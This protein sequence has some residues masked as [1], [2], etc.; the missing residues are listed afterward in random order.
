MSNSPA[1]ADA[2]DLC[3]LGGNPLHDR[4][5]D[6]ALFH[7]ALILARGA[8]DRRHGVAA[9]L[10]HPVQDKRTVQFA[11]LAIK[12]RV[13]AAAD[14][15]TQ[16]THN[17]THVISSADRL[18]MPMRFSRLW[19]NSLARRFFEHMGRLHGGTGE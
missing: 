6:G 2:Y 8:A 5:A 19:G 12:M 9:I 3:G 4:G 11:P 7:H 15:E 16:E 18:K 14:A 17:H 10:A 13:P 1:R